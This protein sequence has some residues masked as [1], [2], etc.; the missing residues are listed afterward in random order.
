MQTNA[1]I[2]SVTDQSI[3]IRKLEYTEDK[4]LLRGNSH[5][6]TTTNCSPTNHL[7]KTHHKTNKQ[8]R[9]ENILTYSNN[10][11]SATK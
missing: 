3:L 5:L 6:T 4:S 10:V 8:E 9:G 1:L 2:P 11:I 7:C